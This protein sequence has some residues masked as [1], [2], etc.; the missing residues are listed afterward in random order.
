MTQREERQ[1]QS[2]PQMN[3]QTEHRLSEYRLE[4]Q[5]GVESGESIVRKAKD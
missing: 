4:K 2:E 5:S 1:W 3:R